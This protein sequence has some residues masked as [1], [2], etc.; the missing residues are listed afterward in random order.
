M[1][2]LL[3]IQGYV[4]Y[5]FELRLVSM[6]KQ[7][8]SLFKIGHDTYRIPFDTRYYQDKKSLQREN[9]DQDV[10]IHPPWQGNEN[11]Q[12][13]PGNFDVPFVPY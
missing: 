13:V 3:Y 7:K 9:K 11:H 1:S 6:D 2:C 5:H 4:S 10:L 12:Y 8:M